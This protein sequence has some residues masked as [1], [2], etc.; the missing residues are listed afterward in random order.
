VNCGQPTFAG[1]TPS[2]YLVVA[3]SLGAGQFSYE[4]NNSAILGFNAEL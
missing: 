3:A 1:S 4:P 2:S